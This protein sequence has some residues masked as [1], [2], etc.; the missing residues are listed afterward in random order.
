MGNITH[1]VE[2]FAADDRLCLAVEKVPS[3]TVEKST[4]PI[5]LKQVDVKGAIRLLSK[6]ILPTPNC[7]SQRSS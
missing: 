1:V 7:K 3:K 5:I 4:L 2:L 6:L